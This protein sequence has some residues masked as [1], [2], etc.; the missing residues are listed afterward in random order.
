MAEFLNSYS[1]LPEELVGSAQAL[2]A[3]R[4]GCSQDGWCSADE[5][6]CRTDNSCS[7]DSCSSDGSCGSDTS[8]CNTDTT[9]CSV[10]GSCSRDSCSSDGVCSDTCSSDGVCSDTPAVVK[11]SA[12][13][14]ITVV[15]TTSDS[16][17]IRMSSIARADH[18]EIA[19]RRPSD[20]SA[21]YEDA[22]SLTYTITGLAA[23]TTYVINY[24]GVNSGGRG[25]FM[26]SAVT[27]KTKS[28]ATS[29]S[30]TYAGLNS[31]GVPVRGSTKM[32]GYGIYVTADE[33]NELA[34]LVSEVTGSGV[35]RVTSGDTIT[36]AVVNT[37]ASALGIRAVSRESTISASFFNRL[38]NAYN[39][40]V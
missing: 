32:A 29:F 6:D 12:S 11:P 17:T 36:A 35:A 2:A 38:M 27:T 21:L 23:S 7:P 30:W 25:P 39:A 3:Q 20:T 8:G 16:I 34:E 14:S 5:W 24:R 19:Y 31:A 10:D 37:M 9:D 18:Y 26:S 4:A 15:S 40:L 22:Y 33:W 1:G 13:G 28:A